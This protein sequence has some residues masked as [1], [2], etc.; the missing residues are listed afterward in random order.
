MAGMMRIILAAAAF[1]ILTLPSLVQFQADLSPDEMRDLRKTPAVVDLAVGEV[2]L[3]PYIR[4]CIHQGGVYTYGRQGLVESAGEYGVY[5]RVRREPDGAV[6]VTSVVGA[7]SS[8]TAAD[9]LAL[10]FTDPSSCEITN[11]PLDD[12]IPV[13]TIDGKSRISEIVTKT[14]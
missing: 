7:K 13:A 14:P 10:S 1:T 4:F 2:G 11:Y 3:I 5:Y 9:A 6:S 8:Q 12:F